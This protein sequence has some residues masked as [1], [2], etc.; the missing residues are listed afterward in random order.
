MFLSLSLLSSLD[1]SDFVLTGV[2]QLLFPPGAL[3]DSIVIQILDDELP[4]SIESFSVSL[5]PGPDVVLTTALATVTIN[6]NDG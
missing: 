2:G 4:E 1:G 3:V 6:D 5:S